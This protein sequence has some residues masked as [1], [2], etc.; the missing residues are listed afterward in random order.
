[1]DDVALLDVGSVKRIGS[2]VKTVEDWRRSGGTSPDGGRSPDPVQ[3]LEV[4][5]PASSGL[6]PAKPV[7]WS[8]A[9]DDFVARGEVRVKALDAAGLREGDHVFGRF[10]GPTEDGEYGLYVARG[11]KTAS[12][13]FVTGVAV[14]SAACNEDG[15]VDVVLDVTR[16]TAVLTA[17]G[18]VL[19]VI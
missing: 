13:S 6:Y 3:L 7:A 8:A 4:T 5:G 1:M 12:V 18:L 2:A 17:D 10:S 16:S 9:D 19:R 14:A 15:T 11:G